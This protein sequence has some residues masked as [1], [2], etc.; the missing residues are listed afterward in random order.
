M[1]DKTQNNS[2]RTIPGK[3]IGLDK[4]QCIYGVNSAYFGHGIIDQ[5]HH[6]HLDNQTMLLAAPTSKNGEKQTMVCSFHLRG[7]GFYNEQW[8]SAESMQVYKATENRDYYFRLT[9]L[10]NKTTKT[11]Y[12]EKCIYTKNELIKFLNKY[13][14]QLQPSF[15]NGKDD[16]IIDSF[17]EFINK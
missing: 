3:W 17:Y 1:K 10:Y 12:T 7:H 4:T 6:K 9:E 11:L 15:A 2:K 5:E 8:D 16:S 13:F 14:D